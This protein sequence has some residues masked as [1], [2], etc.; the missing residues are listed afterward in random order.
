MRAPRKGLGGYYNA[1]LDTTGIAVAIPAR[2]R[3]F[4]IT[5]SAACYCALADDATL[6]TFNNATYGSIGTGG[7]HSFERQA[8]G[9]TSEDYVHIA[10]ATGT[11]I[12]AVAFF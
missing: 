1:A 3:G 10:A 12:V 2:A 9:L 11:A 5:V 7:P 6:G 4:V 8:G